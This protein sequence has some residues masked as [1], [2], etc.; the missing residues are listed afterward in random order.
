M[1]PIKHSYQ[2]CADEEL[3]SFLSEGND[4]AFDELYKR[5]AQKMF[6][7]FFRMLWK[8]KE[9]A[10]DNTQELFLK[11]V[12]HVGSFE[13][14]RSFSTWLYSIANNMCKNEY[15]K[16]AT[17]AKADSTQAVQPLTQPAANPDLRRFREAVAQ[18]TGELPEEKKTL[19][20]LRFQ[21]NLSVP[22]ISRIMDI[23]EGTVKSRI[24]YLLKEMKEKLKIFE[25]LNIY[26]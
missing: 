7:Y 24:F 20:I 22:D 3:L 23:P 6:S 25:T 13:T 12:R 16:A 10:E 19:F 5:Y 18:C 11:L 4:P 8:N 17:R 9:L 26:P 14:G 1:R 2:D 15:R 21:E